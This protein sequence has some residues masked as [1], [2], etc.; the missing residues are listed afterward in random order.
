MSGPSGYGSFNPE[1]SFVKVV[2]LPGSGYFVAWFERRN[3]YEGL[4]GRFLGPTG[5][6]RGR[7]LHLQP[8]GQPVGLAVVN[9]NLLI[10]WIH[11][12]EFEPPVRAQFF[13]L[14]GH[15]LGSVML[16]T[17]GSPVSAAWT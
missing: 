3:S 2:A 15:P 17:E 16:L 10:A 4:V 9:G 6:P 8:Y 5:R 7:A 14:S 1:S 13:D 12:T 11:E